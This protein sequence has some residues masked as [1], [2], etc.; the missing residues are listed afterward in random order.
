VVGLP[1]RRFC[2]LIL[3]R[4]DSIEPVISVR[5]RARWRRLAVACATPWH[6]PHHGAPGHGRFD[7]I[8]VTAGAWDISPSW[9]A[10]LDD[11]GTFVV[12]LWMNDCLRR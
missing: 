8:M 10:Q 6:L 7:A 11:S 9:I 1:E 3:I 12:Q 2:I 4:I 5:A